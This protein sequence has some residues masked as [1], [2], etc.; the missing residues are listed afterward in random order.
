MPDIIAPLAL[1][2]TL[3]TAGMLGL[4]YLFL[5]VRVIQGRY[6]HRVALGDAGNPDLAALIRAHGNF[7]EYV[8]LLLVLMALVEASGAARVPLAGCGAAL[9]AAR[10]A[11]AVGMAIPRVPNPWRAAGTVL[12]LSLLPVLSLWSLLLSL[13]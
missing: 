9:V 8:P 10:V 6:R 1:P 13:D 5:S 11:H 12:T 3:A 2:A 4:V 7:A